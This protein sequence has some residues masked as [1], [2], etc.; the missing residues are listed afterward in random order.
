MDTF[1]EPA[2][3]AG[4]PGGFYSVAGAHFAD[5]FGKIVADRAFGQT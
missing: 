5:G 4:H 3:G 1:L 2:F